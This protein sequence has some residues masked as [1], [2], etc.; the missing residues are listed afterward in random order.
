MANGQEFDPILKSLPHE[1]YLDAKVASVTADTDGWYYKPGQAVKISGDHTVSAA[2]DGSII[3]GTVKN[4]LNKNDIGDLSANSTIQIG[5]FKG[6]R[7]DTIIAG[8]LL[9]AGD[10]V[11]VNYLGKALKSGATIAGTVSIDIPA[12]VVTTDVEAGVT[13]TVEGAICTTDIPA[14]SGAT[15]ISEDVAGTCLITTNLPI[16][17]VWK[18]AAADAAAEVII[19]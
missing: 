19:Y 12:L 17:I 1:G 8:E 16:G 13:G 4:G 18:G 6:R 7:I 14:L 5:L 3:L 2:T 15:A 9:A 11:Y 10:L